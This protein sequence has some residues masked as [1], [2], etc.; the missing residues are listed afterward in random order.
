LN[1]HLQAPKQRRVSAISPRLREHRNL[2]D[3]ETLAADI[4][5]RGLRHPVTVARDGRL[6]LGVRRL[7][8]CAIAGLEHADCWQVTCVADVIAVI[9]LENAD[10]L[11]SG[12]AKYHVPATLAA[13]ASQDLAMRELEWWPRGPAAPDR[14]DHRAELV[15]A[16][17]GPG[18][19][20]LLSPF[21][22]ARLHSL[23]AAAAGWQP[24]PGGAHRL[25]IPQASRRAAMQA[26]A[27]LDHRDTRM[28]NPVYNR[29]RGDRPQTQPEMKPLAPAGVGPLVPVITGFAG[30]LAATGLPRQDVT[31]A[32]VDEIDS[33]VCDL[34]RALTSYRKT[35]RQAR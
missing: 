15:G 35:L 26:L 34:L 29:W 16:L 19:A 13:L 5:D 9:D 4:S 24:G 12:D 31:N 18:E 21:Q 23:A 27:M 11:A 32:Q 2:G 8:A 3:L 17:L 7:A 10:D 1:P 14:R 6:I 30:A 25:A 28:V 22:Y 20:R 33:A